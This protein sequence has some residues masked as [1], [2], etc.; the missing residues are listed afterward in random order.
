MAHRKA[1]GW[2]HQRYQAGLNQGSMAYRM[3]VS[4]PSYGYTGPY[5]HR[6]A[7]CA[8]RRSDM[9][10]GPNGPGNNYG[11]KNRPYVEQKPQTKG[12]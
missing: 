10:R 8:M 4:N 1:T 2:Y 12:Y 9:Y 6:F 5:I 3:S 7:G 11:Y